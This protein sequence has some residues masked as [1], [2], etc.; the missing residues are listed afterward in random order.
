PNPRALEPASADLYRLFGLNKR[1]LELLA[2]AAPK[3]SYY[4]RQPRGRRMFD[5]R[6]KGAALAI[7]GASSAEDQKLIDQ[8]QESIKTEQTPDAFVR[9]FLEAKGFLGVQ[10]LFDALATH[11][12]AANDFAASELIQAIANDATPLNL[13]GPINAA[14]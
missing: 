9:A 11:P 8:V 2:F 10:G 12:A 13:G 5:L 7:C 14:Q 4:I 1:Q 3:R 6:L